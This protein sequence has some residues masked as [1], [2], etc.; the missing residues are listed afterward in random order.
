MLKLFIKGDVDGFLVQGGVGLSE[1]GE[2]DGVGVG[3]AGG[4]GVGLGGFAGLLWGVAA[5]GV[6][7]FQ[8]GL[9]A[10][11]PVLQVGQA[12]S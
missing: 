11:L 3:A 1:G 12:V 6:E 5:A 9:V 10:R 7:D 8:H 2:Q 4:A